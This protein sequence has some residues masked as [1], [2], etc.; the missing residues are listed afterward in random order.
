ML[1]PNPGL[2][3]WT[4]ITFALL[5]I[6]LRAFAWKPLLEAL[7]KREDSVRDSLHRA[8]QARAEAERLI[9]E[10]RR[11]L[12]LAGQEGKRILN[13][14][15][16]LAQQLQKELTDKAQEQ[17]RKMIDQARAEIERNKDAALVQLR[18]EVAALAL[19]AAEKILSETLDDAKHRR[20]IDT[21]LNDLP[22]N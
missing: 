8:E 16:T 5:V 11:Q 3:V 2:I 6:V 9:E 12:A 10:N 17:S 15:R 19:G 21:Y 18:G 20:I 4:I 14:S 13:E 22:A 7:Q 1:N